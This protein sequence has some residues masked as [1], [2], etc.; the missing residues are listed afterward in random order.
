MR[1]YDPIATEEARQGDAGARLRAERVED[2]LEGAD[3]IVLVTEWPEFLA[4]DWQAVAAS[5]AG[6]VVID[7]RNALDPVAVRAAGLRL[8]G[9]RRR[10]RAL[11]RH[12]RVI[13]AGG[14]GTRLR[15]LTS[16]VAK[17]VVTLVDRP[18]IVYMLE[19]LRRHGVDRRDPLAA[20][21]SPT[22]CAPVLGDGC[23]LRPAAALRRGVRAAR[24]RRSRSRSPPSSWRRSLP[25]L[26]RRHPHRHRPRGAAARSTSATGASGDAGARRG[27]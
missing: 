5:M 23:A 7:G 19:W 6:D 1:A 21:S 25:R 13:L 12:R 22:A 11:R 16:R 2:A 8:R 4:L 14:E 3:A 24:H 10:M 9:D 18:F 17:P 27:R 20:A 15:P 26:Q